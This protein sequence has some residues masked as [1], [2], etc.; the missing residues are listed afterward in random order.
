MGQ[1]KF[2]KTV[3]TMKNHKFSSVCSRIATC[4]PGKPGLTSFSEI[5]ALFFVRFLSFRKMKLQDIQNGRSKT[6]QAYLKKTGWLH[7]WYESSSFGLNT[8]KCKRTLSSV[9]TPNLGAEAVCSQL[10]T[11]FLQHKMFYNVLTYCVRIRYIIKF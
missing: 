3:E 7:A 11:V 10:Y 8:S 5:L 2:R 9:R 1:S 6:F 4:K